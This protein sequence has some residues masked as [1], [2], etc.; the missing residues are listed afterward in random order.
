MSLWKNAYAWT[1]PRRSWNF[2]LVSCAKDAIKP[3]CKPGNLLY[4]SV[5]AM[6]S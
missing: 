5:L 1:G 4:H 6:L 2:R 3:V